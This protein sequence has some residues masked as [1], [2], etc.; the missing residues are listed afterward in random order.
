MAT[1]HAVHTITSTP[2]LVSPEGVHSGFD[3]TIQ[4]NS[5]TANAFVGGEGV[6]SSSYG[7]KLKP[8]TAISFEL[9][10]KNDLYVVSDGTATVSVIRIGLE[11]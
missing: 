1:F 5:A 11:D 2:V 9:P 8:D 4:N 6:S 10:S 7:F 3:I